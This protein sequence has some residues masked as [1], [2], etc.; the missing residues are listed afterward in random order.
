MLPEGIQGLIGRKDIMNHHPLEIDYP[1]R[2]PFL[3]IVC[4]GR[5]DI[6]SFVIDGDLIEER[7]AE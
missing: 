2:R 5:F 7:L 6:R 3:C 1:P 4:S